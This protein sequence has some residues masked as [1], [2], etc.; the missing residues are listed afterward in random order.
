MRFID[1]SVGAYFSLAHPVHALVKDERIY[2]QDPRPSNNDKR[3][4]T[5]SFMSGFVT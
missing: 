2:I 1:R 3:T 5:I 4:T